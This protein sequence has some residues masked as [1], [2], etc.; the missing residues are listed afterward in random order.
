MNSVDNLADFFTKVQPSKLFCRMRDTIMNVPQCTG[1][2]CDLDT[3]ALSLTERPGGLTL[4]FLP[5][6]Y[7]SALCSY[8]RHAR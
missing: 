2:H 8:V 7:S 3:G 6:H 5:V 1:G 4:L